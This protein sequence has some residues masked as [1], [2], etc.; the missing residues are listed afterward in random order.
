MNKTT[1]LKFI[2]CILFVFQS[3][4]GKSQVSKCDLAEFKTKYSKGR[5]EEVDKDLRD[6]LENFKD[7][8][9][10][11]IDAL[12]W[13]TMNSIMLVKKNQAI[14]DVNQLLDTNSDYNFRSDDSYAFKELVT[15]YRNFGVL[16]VTSVS[17]FEETLNEAPATIYVITAKDIENRGYL[18]IE[19]IFHDIPGFSISRSNGPA[20]SLLYP[21]GYRSTLNDKFLLLI[22]GIEQN[23][24]N[25]DNAVINRQVPLSN[26][27]QIEVIYG[28]SSTMYGANAF[29]AVINIITKNAT[30]DEGNSFSADIQ[31]NYGTWETNFVDA[32]VSKKLKDGFISVT[33]RL[34][35][36][37]EMDLT[38]QGYDYNPSNYDYLGQ[39][40]SLKDS[41]AINF[42]AANPIGTTMDYFDYN[43]MPGEESVTL[44]PAGANQMQILD[45]KFYNQNTGIGFNNRVNT[46]FVN[47][48]FKISGFTFGIETFKSNTGALPWYPRSL[49]IASRNLSRW[50]TWNSSVYIKYEKKIN[51]NLFLTNLASYRLHTLDGDSNLSTPNFYSTN[52]EFQ[53]LL[54]GKL[55]NISTSYRYRSSNQLRNEL[56]LFYK[57][58]NFNI[59]TGLEFRQGIFQMD[60]LRGDEPDPQENIPD[61]TQVGIDGG[62]QSNKLDIGYFV[63][64]KYSFS[65]N[66]SAT[67]GGRVDYNLFRSS[68]GYGFVFNPRAVL[69]YSKK[70]KFTFKAIYSEAFKELS[71]LTRYTNNDTRIANPTLMPEKVKNFEVSA[72]V[73]P[74]EGF[75][76][77]VNAFN[78]L[79][80]NVVAEVSIG[81]GQTQN[82]A[83]SKGSNIKGVQ[84]TLSY[85]YST[86]N[87][88]ANYTYLNPKGFKKSPDSDNGNEDEDTY[89]YLR[90]SDIPSSS[91][92]VGLNLAASKKLN[93]NLRANYV[94]KRKTGAQTSGSLNPLNEIDAYF[95]AHTNVNYELFEGLKIGILIN[96]IFNQKYYH[97]GV[98]T[99][100]E[101]SNSSRSLQNARSIMFRAK[102]KF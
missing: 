43:T 33:G 29:S 78:Y 79:Y 6:C 63:Q 81:N 20:Y 28:P 76:I 18:D 51:Q 68:E 77:E 64:G 40:N 55:P 23:D 44:T 38:E 27:K 69:V 86:F 1:I 11:Y 22:D 84:A 47:T 17:K 36:S 45:S 21:R 31:T 7:N 71:F 85:E 49:R 9:A 72:I 24:L 99:A 57:K 52:L 89:E 25:S 90:I 19:Q 13:L 41:L 48:K 50:I 82:Q 100:D 91:A 12:R 54:D 59:I 34:F 4:T 87:F 53:D 80:S 2:F 8:E 30:F 37:D 32:T 96:N 74:I 65:K 42:I 88:W 15:K 93:V 97:P 98:R 10:T 75:S 3:Y 39:S 101:V 70:D 46:W 94:G 92:N 58:N 16:K 67:L 61:T 26:I 35:H 83:S 5:F 73:K 60:Y 95:T 14:K 102:Y 66:F 56:K 62:N